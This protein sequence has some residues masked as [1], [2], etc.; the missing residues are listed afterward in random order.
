MRLTERLTSFIVP[1]ALVSTAYLSSQDY[2]RLDRSN[3]ISE[4]KKIVRMLERPFPTY[5]IDTNNDGNADYK[6]QFFFSGTLGTFSV[7]DIPS[8]EEK[9]RFEKAKEDYAKSKI[10][11]DPRSLTSC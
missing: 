1:I 4:D 5:L 3:E 11:Y 7:T 9:R 10:L 8:I 6:R 2:T